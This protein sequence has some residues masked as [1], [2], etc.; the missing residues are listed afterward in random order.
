[1]KRRDRAS[2]LLRRIS[3][4]PLSWLDLSFSKRLLIVALA[5]WLG[6][7]GLWFLF[8]LAHNGVT[9]FLPIVCA[10]WLFRYRGLLVS[11]FLNGLAF[12][13]T[14]LLLLQ[15]MLSDQTFMLGGIIGFITSL[16]V[17][18]VVCW[19]RTAVDMMQQARQSALASEQ[20]RIAAMQAEYHA[21][22]AYEHER[23]INELKDRFLLHVSHE[24]RTPLTVLGGFLE[25]LKGFVDQ[26]EPEERTQMLAQALESHEEL[27]RLVNG[28]LD[29]V[30]AA[31]TMPFPRCEEV[32][33]HQIVQNVL[34]HLDP[35]EVRAYTV[36][37]KV[38]ELLKV[39]ADPDHLYHVLQNLLSNVLKYV[40]KQTTIIIEAAQMT[41]LVR[42]SIQDEGPGIPTDELPLLFEK[43]VRLK[44]D[45]AGPT[46]GTGLGLYTCRYLVESMGGR[47][48]AESSGCAGE[49][50]RFCLT[51]P[52]L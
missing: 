32:A 14:Y 46:R 2:I 37:I 6:E 1:M 16:G 42:L 12:Q 24:L 23:K 19:L 18:L 35:E 30:V 33:V 31:E 40:P 20:K 29:A 47:I 17:G 10:C 3:A 43:F 15:G 4:L 36:C 11:M 50:S 34:S 51:L 9:M 27:V 38:A 26:M 28:V 52:S 48:W 44:R 25:L 13:L 7:I 21:S 41:S 5:Y 22:L 45:I 39:R 49:G 8:P